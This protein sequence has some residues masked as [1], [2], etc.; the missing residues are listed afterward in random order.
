MTDDNPL[1]AAMRRVDISD[2][3]EVHAEIAISQSISAPVI[4]VRAELDILIR[5]NRAKRERNE[6]EI[7]EATAR[8]LATIEALTRE[9]NDAIE[10]LIAIDKQLTMVLNVL[11]LTNRELS[12]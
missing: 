4:S 2:N 11:E 3:A 1:I 5:N 10:R 6:S 8:H 9:H 12:K 7:N